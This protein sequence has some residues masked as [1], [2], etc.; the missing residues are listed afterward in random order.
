[1][2]SKAI[3]VPPLLPSLVTLQPAPNSLRTC[4]LSKSLM[5]PRFTPGGSGSNP[6]WAS[7]AR[8]P[9]VLPAG[10]VGMQPLDG[11]RS[12]RVAIEAMIDGAHAA[13]RDQR[14][15]HEAIRVSKPGGQSA[16]ARVGSRLRR[17]HA[18]RGMRGDGQAVVAHRQMP[19]DASQRFGVERTR[20]ERCEHV[21]IGTI[22]RLASHVRENTPVRRS[23]AAVLGARFGA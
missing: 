7:Q 11:N 20:D 4:P 14:A 19:L 23:V 12:P 2:L 6:T 16:R 22:V 15:E 9:F 13:C 8:E 10:A 3:D 18:M 5:R 17:R 21:G 1:M